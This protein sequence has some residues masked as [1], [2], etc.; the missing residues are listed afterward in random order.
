MRKKELKKEYYYQ[1]LGLV[2][3]VVTRF[4]NNLMF[5]GKRILH[6]KFFIVL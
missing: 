6:L 4:V 2:S 5:D 3:T 1:I